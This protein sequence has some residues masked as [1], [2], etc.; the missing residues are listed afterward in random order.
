M[1]QR[2]K[3]S[4]AARIDGFTKLD[5]DG[6]RLYIAV[7]MFAARPIERIVVELLQGDRDLFDAWSQLEGPASDTTSGSPAE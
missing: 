3:T 5:D 7:G 1:V 2:G 4:N 6:V